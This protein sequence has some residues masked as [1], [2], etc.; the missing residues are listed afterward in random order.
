MRHTQDAVRACRQLLQHLDEPFV[1]TSNPLLREHH[2]DAAQLPRY[3]R[4]TLR[5]LA[6]QLGEREQ[7]ILLRCDLGG[8][9]HKKVAFELGLSMRQFYRERAAMT[10]R[11]AA[12]LNEHVRDG[13][14]PATAI[15]V[16]GLELARA[17][18]M[19]H[20]GQRSM[21]LGLLQ[22]I[23]ASNAD[24]DV[25]L[26]ARCERLTMLAE[27]GA[28]ACAHAELALLDTDRRAANDTSALA[29]ARVNYE[30]WYLLWCGGHDVQAWEL[31]NRSLEPF[32]LSARL[33]GRAAKEFAA[34]ALTML[35]RQAFISGRFQD[36][37]ARSER[38]HDL[39]AVLHDPPVWA[40][41]DARILSGV[42]YTAISPGQLVPA[43]LLEAA[44]L[45]VQHGLSEF[46]VMAAMGVSMNEQIHGNNASALSRM[47]NVLPL[48]R[49]AASRLIFAHV[50]LQLAQIRVESG[51]GALALRLLAEAR[52]AYPVRNYA[53]MYN[54][55]VASGAYAV[56]RDFPRAQRAAAD[57]A[58]AARVQKNASVEGV[59]LLALA[60]SLV[61]LNARSEAVDAAQ[62]AVE[63]LETYGYPSQLLRA[64]ELAASLT[65]RRRFTERARELK[66]VLA[67]GTA[68]IM[69]NQA[70][71]S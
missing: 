33:E 12:M 36:G 65:K 57:A 9:P 26:A 21:A 71:H 7:A 61:G 16:G 22:S 14:A 38:A 41:I 40:R 17:T 23:A 66:R 53:W 27:E 32:V 30:R 31:A 50:C 47:E 51:D 11:L 67:P 1:L 70:M 58:S 39:L 59:A 52:D 56:L 5:M 45:A 4:S 20:S 24:R 54:N 19:R 44:A 2:H 42:F 64:Y 3:L 35:A 15:D 10:G 68:A 49:N 28:F 25:R 55:V 18:A 34:S 69:P 60:Q 13:D 46:V 43:E 29:D 48:A 63:R 62:A 6:L 37:F 8:R